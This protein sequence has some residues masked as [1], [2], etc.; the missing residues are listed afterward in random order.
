VA[1]PAFAAGFLATAAFLLGPEAGLRLLET[2][3]GVEGGLIT[4]EG[5]LLPTSGLA[6]VADLGPGGAS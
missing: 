1:P 2:S 5:R 4:E 6:R 3:P